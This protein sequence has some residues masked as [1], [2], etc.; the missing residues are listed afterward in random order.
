MSLKKEV[1]AVGRFCLYVL[2]VVAVVEIYLRCFVVNFS[3]L[4][5]S[6][7]QFYGQIP[8]PLAGVVPRCGWVNRVGI[9]QS[10]TVAKETVWPSGQRA[11]RPDEEKSCSKRVLMLGCSYTYG[12]G[13]YDRDTLAWLLNERFP[14]I[15]FD[16]YGVRRWGTYQ[17][18]LFAQYLLL[19]RKEKY[20]QVLYFFI[21]DHVRRHFLWNIHGV[22][23][24]N[25]YFVVCP[26]V[27]GSGGVW[28]FFPSCSFDWP[29]QDTWAG[30]HFAHTL[31][32]VNRV[33]TNP[34]LS[35][36]KDPQQQHNLDIEG[37]QTVRQC[38]WLLDQV[39]RQA[40][41]KFAVVELTDN[42]Y[43]P[44]AAQEENGGWPCTRWNVSFEQ[45]ND[46]LYRNHGQLNLHP[47]YRA[48]K[49]WF[50]RLIPY[51]QAEL[52]ADNCLNRKK[53]N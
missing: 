1:M 47:N 35:E 32:A 44:E 16:N 26:A 10:E 22:L 24:L 50:N 52:G 46:P 40:G 25:A 53:D 13:V 4:G 43:V 51:I 15:Q 18:L 36:H 7:K 9:G 31:Y 45:L 38:A 2:I 30:V 33:R 17:C 14:N 39:C 12:M 37:W 29:G 11:S 49:R 19:E 34:H 20:D 21:D 8:R 42:Q 41:A 3:A 5:E 27:S 23:D 6:R 28:K 48:Q